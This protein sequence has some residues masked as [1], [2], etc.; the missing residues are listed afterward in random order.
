MVKKSYEINYR[1]QISKIF[2]DS[3]GNFIGKNIVENDESMISEKLS[4]NPYRDNR[5]TTIKLD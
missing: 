3:A 4:N 1:S 5:K 2:Q